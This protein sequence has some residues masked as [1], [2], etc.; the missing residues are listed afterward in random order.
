MINPVW[1]IYIKGADQLI[2]QFSYC[3]G[4][5]PLENRNEP[6]KE[7]TK[8]TLLY[9]CYKGVFS[10]TGK[11]L[12]QHFFG[13]SCRIWDKPV[14]CGGGTSCCTAQ[15]QSFVLSKLHPPVWGVTRIF[16]GIPRMDGPQLFLGILWCIDATPLL[17]LV[18]LKKM[19]A[20]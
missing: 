6:N 17:P 2:L 8:G 19:E 7:K 20:P 18:R 1:S 12:K 3:F 10:N 14:W 9:N 13:Y 4:I 16:K 15:D 5:G 11:G